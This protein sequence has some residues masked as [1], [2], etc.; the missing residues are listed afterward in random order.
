M[1]NGLTANQTKHTKIHG[2]FLWTNHFARLKVKTRNGMGCKKPSVFKHQMN[3]KLLRYGMLVFACM[4][5]AT[6]QIANAQ[7]T[8][9]LSHLGS[10][11]D[12]G[13]YVQSDEWDAVSFETGTAASGYGLDSIQLR[14][15]A[16]AGSPSGF[17]LSLYDNNGGVPGNSLGLLSGSDPTGAG[18]YTFTASGI[19]LTPSTVYW[20]VAKSSDS[21]L[22]GDS[23]YWAFDPDSYTSTDGWSLGG[24]NYSHDGSSWNGGGGSPFTLA[25]NASAVPE[26]EIYSLTGLGLFAILL[27][28]RKEFRTG[29][30]S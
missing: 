25:V 23:F 14:I 30:K 20:V 7:G 27:R 28:H 13:W 5:Q 8:T 2:N 24:N 17:E 4:G 11:D 21:S 22:S 12:T 29:C 18:V 1:Q 3:I 10:T 19:M 16:I 26:P 15:A 9:Y 6:P